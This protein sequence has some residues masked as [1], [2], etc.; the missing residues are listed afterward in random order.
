MGFT[1]FLG[2]T[3]NNASSAGWALMSDSMNHI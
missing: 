2:I 1:L 3:P